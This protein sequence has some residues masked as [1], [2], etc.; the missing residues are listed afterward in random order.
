MAIFPQTL[1]DG[2]QVA[3][4]LDGYDEGKIENVRRNPAESGDTQIRD[5]WMGRTKYFTECDLDVSPA[6]G[7]AFIA[8]KDNNRASTVTF[9]SYDV[10]LQYDDEN[11]GTGDGVAVNFTIPAK[12]TAAQVVEVDGVV[13]TVVTHYNVTAGSG[14]LGEDRVVFTGGNA[15]ANGLAVTISY[16]GRH[17]YTVDMLIL[18]WRTLNSLG[19]KAIHLRVKEAF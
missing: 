14:A 11:I 4:L 16:T 19:R 8:F 10:S 6:D 9:F 12:N 7:A 18:A 5:L 1:A 15:P 13:K 17:R 2:Q 3:P